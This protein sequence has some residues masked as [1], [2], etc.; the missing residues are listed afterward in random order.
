M[1]LYTAVAG[2]KGETQHPPPEVGSDS[3]ISCARWNA[4]H[5]VVFE[6]VDGTHVQ[7]YS[8]LIKVLRLYAGYMHEVQA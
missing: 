3:Y 7:V 8:N 5:V 4:V 6:T 1:L 2:R